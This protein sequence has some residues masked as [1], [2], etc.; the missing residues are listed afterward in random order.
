MG[1]PGGQQATPEQVEAMLRRMHRNEFVR[2]LLA[3]L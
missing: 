1:G 2:Y 3:I